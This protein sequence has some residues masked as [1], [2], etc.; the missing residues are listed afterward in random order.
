VVDGLSVFSDFDLL[1]SGGSSSNS[2]NPAIGSFC[3]PCCGSGCQAQLPPRC[4]RGRKLGFCRVPFPVNPN[5]IP[6]KSPGL[7]RNE[8]PW[9][10]GAQDNNPKY[11]FSGAPRSRRFC[12][13]SSN[14]LEQSGACWQ[15][16]VEAA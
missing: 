6:Q 3:V 4:E 7:A 5:G 16:C 10:T 8:L 15:S 9:V 14:A 12:V 1:F 2:F 11:V 13:A